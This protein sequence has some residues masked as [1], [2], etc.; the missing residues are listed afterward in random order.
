MLLRSNTE[1]NA[2]F[3]GENYVRLTTYE[4]L[5]TFWDTFK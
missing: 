5:N 1:K 3:V 2:H 4:A